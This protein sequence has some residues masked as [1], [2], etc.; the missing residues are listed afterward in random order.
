MVRVGESMTETEMNKS[1]LW[2]AVIAGLVAVLILLVGVLLLMYNCCPLLMHNCWR[3][4][5]ADYT[6]VSQSTL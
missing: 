6:T 5:A 2:M 1:L 4:S 3:K